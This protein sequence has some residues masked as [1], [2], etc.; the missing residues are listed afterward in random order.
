MTAP[1]A[2][3]GPARGLPLAAGTPVL[4]LPARIETR[5]AE[6]ADGSPC[7]LLRVYPD[8]VGVSSFESGLTQE[9]TNAGQAYWDQLWRAGSPPPDPDAE[10]APW[11]VTGRRLHPATGGLDRAKPDTR[12]PR[13]AASHPDPAGPAS[14]TRPR[15]PA[16]ADPRQLL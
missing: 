9:E 3:A 7:L 12:Q 15:L 14:V 2:A 6:A 13:A 5:F 8:T 4:L 1:A 11:R 10:R 16:P